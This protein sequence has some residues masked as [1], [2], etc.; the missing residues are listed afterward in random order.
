[1]LCSTELVR[2]LKG[3]CSSTM[4]SCRSLHHRRRTKWSQ[5][6]VDARPCTTGSRKRF[7]SGVM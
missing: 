5:S 3:L 7:L 2:P 1:M 4:L 6:C